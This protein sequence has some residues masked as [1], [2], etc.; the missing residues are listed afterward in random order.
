MG[1]VTC[2]RPDADGECRDLMADPSFCALCTGTQAKIEQQQTLGHEVE[3]GTAEHWFRA[4]F[5]GWCAKCKK[6][7]EVGEWIARTTT[8]RFV[9]DCV[10]YE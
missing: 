2:Q 9:C 5:P 6:D 4:K 8:G 10:L 7:T 3:V 1:S